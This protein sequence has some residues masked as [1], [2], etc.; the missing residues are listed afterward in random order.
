[1]LP[2]E[3]YAVAVGPTAYHVRTLVPLAAPSI[4]PPVGP[5]FVAG[6]LP[7]LEGAPPPPPLSAGASSPSSSSV[8]GSSRRVSVWEAPAPGEEQG[9]MEAGAAGGGSVLGKRGRGGRGSKE[10]KSSGSSESSEQAHAPK[11]KKTLIAC[12][13]CRARK[14]RCDGQKPSCAN[15]RKRSNPCTYEAQPKRRGPGKTP[16]GSSRKRGRPADAGQDTEPEAGSLA[17]AGAGMGWR[18]RESVGGSPGR[19]AHS[20][21]AFEPQLTGP[22]P[23]Y[24]GAGSRAPSSESPSSSYLPGAPALVPFTAYT[25]GPSRSSASASESVQ[26]SATSSAPSV[27]DSEESTSLSTDA[28]AEPLDD[29]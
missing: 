18:G 6:R 9:P 23:M 4:L 27:P 8:A 26:S 11:S 13:F 15:C 22:Q 21:A 1:M 24:P 5:G 2:T 7:V 16:R 12:H 25:P 17:A 28:Y 14:L 20:H 29:L 10:S 3:P 19:E